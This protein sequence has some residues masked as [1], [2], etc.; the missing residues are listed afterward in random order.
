M[1]DPSKTWS[2]CRKLIPRKG[3]PSIGSVDLDDDCIGADQFVSEEGEV[4]R[5]NGNGRAGR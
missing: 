5:S 3:V 1:T 4:G 2:Y